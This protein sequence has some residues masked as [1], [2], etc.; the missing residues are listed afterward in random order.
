LQRGEGG[1]HAE[2]DKH[3]KWADI[4][5]ET[6]KD[7]ALG[8]NAVLDVVE[9]RESSDGYILEVCLKAALPSA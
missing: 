7:R 4:M 3:R 1:R 5:I 9:V 6:R 8:G 2:R